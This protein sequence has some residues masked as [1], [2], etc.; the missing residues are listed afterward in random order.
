MHHFQTTIIFF[1]EHL[2]KDKY[3][4]FETVR[5]INRDGNC[6]DYIEIILMDFSKFQIYYVTYQVNVFNFIALIF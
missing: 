1:F 4:S 6:F 3:W 2:N 5:F